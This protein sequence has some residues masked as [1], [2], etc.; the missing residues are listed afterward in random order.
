MVIPDFDGETFVAFLDISGFKKLM[1]N[2][3]IALSALNTLYS[4]GYYTLKED[5]NKS[6]NNDKIIEGLFVSD[7][8]ILFVNDNL[9]T[10]ERGKERLIDLLKKIKEFSK[11]LEE[12]NV[13]LVCTDVCIDWLCEKA[14]SPMFGAREEARVI[15]E[16]IKSFFV[17]AVLFGSL[18]HGGKAIADIAGDSV[19][20]TI[21]Q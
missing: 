21:E 7:S 4:S 8:A 19:S 17:D 10:I 16:H 1:K 15:Q 3:N 20:I 13:T 12:K 18:K 2:E 9:N 14:Y 6:Y 5:D 11:Q